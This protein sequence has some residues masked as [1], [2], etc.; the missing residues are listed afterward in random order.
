MNNKNFRII[1][2]P[3]RP[4]SYLLATGGVGFGYEADG[5]VMIE[6]GGTFAPIEVEKYLQ[7]NGAAFEVARTHGLKAG[8]A[9]FNA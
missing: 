9:R 2:S 4:V 5:H 3:L 8:R 6:A 1:S 7:D